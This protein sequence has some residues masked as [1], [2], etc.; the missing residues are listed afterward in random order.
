MM[1]NGVVLL[2]RGIVFGADAGWRG[3]LVERRAIFRIDNGDSAAWCS[4]VSE[5][6]C[7]NGR[8]QGGG[9][10]WR[11]GGVT[12]WPCKAMALIFA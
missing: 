2:H 4:G 6:M 10:V 12:G 7:A 1:V 11:H 3:L 8:G 5:W 9:A